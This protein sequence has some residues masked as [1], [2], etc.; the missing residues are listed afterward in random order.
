MFIINKP[1]LSKDHLLQAIITNDDFFGAA[2]D[3]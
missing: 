3:P 2:Y 1:S